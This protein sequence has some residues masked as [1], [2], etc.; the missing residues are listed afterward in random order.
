MGDWIAIT[1]KA[2][3]FPTFIHPLDDNPIIWLSQEDYSPCVSV[4]FYWHSNYPPQFNLG[5]HCSLFANPGNS[6]EYIFLPNLGLSTLGFRWEL[7]WAIWLFSLI[8]WVGLALIG[9]FGSLP[10]LVGEPRRIWVVPPYSCPLVLGAD[11]VYFVF[12]REGV[13]LQKASIECL[14][15]TR[16]QG[17][18]ARST[19]GTVY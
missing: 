7:D 15:S 13:F 6:F 4:G 12:S 14:C 18:W 10:F 16:Q 17:K 2:A 11:Q 8:D 3:I 1:Q 19:L 9:F 5:R